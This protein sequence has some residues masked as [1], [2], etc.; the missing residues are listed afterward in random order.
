MLLSLNLLLQFNGYES[1]FVFADVLVMR[2]DLMAPLEQRLRMV[3]DD[4]FLF[5]RLSF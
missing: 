1:K 3:H 2:H 4:R 5:Y